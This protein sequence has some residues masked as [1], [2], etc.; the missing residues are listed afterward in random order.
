MKRANLFFLLGLIVSTLVLSSCDDEEKIEKSAYIGDYTIK[1]ASLSETLLIPVVSGGNEFDYPLPVGQ[2]IT[3][4]IQS[5][6]L[7][8]L[9]C[10][11]PDASLIELREDYSLY[12]SCTDITFELNAGTWEEKENG[13]ILVLNMNNAAIPSSPTGFSL[14][15]SNVVL[16]N[17]IMSSTTTVPIPKESIAEMIIAESSGQA[18]LSENAP[19]VFIF[20]F[21]M[22][23]K[24]M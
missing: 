2:D 10:N 13:T 12:M 24:K 18:T 6:L 22:E 8:S 19:D 3:E 15:V 21:D 4:M 20:T 7:N 5:S 11:S 1:S 17:S 16:E 9:P 14:T 23:F